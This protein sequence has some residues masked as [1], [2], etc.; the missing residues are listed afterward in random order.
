M[1]VVPI[2][3]ATPTAPGRIGDFD[4]RCEPRNV[5]DTLG[6]LGRL[7]G[8]SLNEP[9]Q[10]LSMF[11]SEHLGAASTHTSS[12]TSA[13]H[14]LDVALVHVAVARM[15]EQAPDAVLTD[16]SGS[17]EP[18]YELVT[19][20]VGQQIAAPHDLAA[21]LPAGQG[22]DFPT[23][24]VLAWANSVPVIAL[25]VLRV[26]AEAARSALAA[27]LDRARTTENFYRGKTVQAI[28]DERFISLTPVAPSVTERSQVVHAAR[29]WS[30]IDAT[31][32]GLTRHGAVLAAAGLGASRGVLISGPPGVGKTALCRVIAA[33]LPVGTTILLVDATTSARG[34]GKLYESLGNL[35]PAAVFLDDID[36]LAGDRRQG[37]EGP[38]LRE[39]LTH[40]D[41]FTPP[42]AVITLATTNVTETID[43]ALI[44]P[45]RFDS[46]IEIGVPDRPGREA[47][48]RR[49]L[50]VFGDFDFGRLASA[51]DGATGADLREV[52]RRAVLERGS[53][54]TDAHLMEV[55]STGRWSPKVT[56]GQYL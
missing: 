17:T 21:A 20:D 35:A 19:V 29:V 6:A 14:G 11:V 15:L 44:R 12:V 10:N 31:I 4:L 55:V 34:L 9:P 7:L 52:V 16:D 28:A 54:L 33:E 41:G 49:Y 23:V 36:L 56:I 53:D 43:P 13:L 46:V 18:G 26:D 42:G 25:H 39:F 45:G 40:L 50:G 1:S 48:L 24:L 27:L 32:G 5:R 3:E 30:E 22:F 2:I 37:T 8:A 38:A 51:T 47:I